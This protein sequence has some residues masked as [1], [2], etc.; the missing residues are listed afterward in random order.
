MKKVIKINVYSEIKK[1]LKEYNG[2]MFGN[3]IKIDDKCSICGRIKECIP[4][5]DENNTLLTV[6]EECVLKEAEK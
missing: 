4:Y 2:P 6:C 5:L 1:Q 3:F